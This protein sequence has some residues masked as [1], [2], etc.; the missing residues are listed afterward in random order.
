MKQIL[1]QFEFVAQN[2][3]HNSVRISPEEI[4]YEA[5]ERSITDIVKENSVA[6]LHEEVYILLTL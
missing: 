6:S 3:S 4:V 5:V 1:V 2:T